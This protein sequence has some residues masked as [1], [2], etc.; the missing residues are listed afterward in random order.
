MGITT[1]TLKEI[2]ICDMDDN[3]AVWHPVMIHG[4]HM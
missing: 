3:I 4:Y 2:K 1:I